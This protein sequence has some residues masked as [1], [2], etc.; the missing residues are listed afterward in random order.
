MALIVAYDRASAYD[1]INSIAEVNVGIICGCMPTLKPLLRRHFPSLLGTSYS[2]A[3]P[4]SFLQ[5]TSS[6]R[7]FPKFKRYF[8]FGAQD[9]VR[10][11]EPENIELGSPMEFADPFRR[12]VVVRHP[13]QHGGWI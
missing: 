13:S 9:H 2:N 1:G 7:S 6:N 10:L 12:P 8:A 3:G 11:P 5:S 4:S